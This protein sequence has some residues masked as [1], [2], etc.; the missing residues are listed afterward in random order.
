MV[1]ISRVYTLSLPLPPTSWLFLQGSGR[2]RYGVR[3]GSRCA[4]GGGGGRR[5]LP[6][7]LEDYDGGSKTPEP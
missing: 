5:A 2:G 7:A 4:V 1:P 6:A 3:E